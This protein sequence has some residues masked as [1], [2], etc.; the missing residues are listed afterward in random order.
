M[1]P[2]ALSSIG[3][4]AN[5]GGKTNISAIKEFFS[6]LSDRPAIPV[7]FRFSLLPTKERSPCYRVAKA[8][9]IISI[10]TM[11]NA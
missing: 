1:V 5:T 3:T 4:K 10:K 6:A 9:C 11:L 7:K 2:F 8:D